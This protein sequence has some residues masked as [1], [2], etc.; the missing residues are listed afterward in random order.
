L[1]ALFVD[2]EREIEELKKILKDPNLKGYRSAIE[3]DLKREN[4]LYEKLKETLSDSP[5]VLRSKNC[6]ANRPARSGGRRGRR[7]IP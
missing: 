4:K 7:N 6:G 5:Y 3:R 2:S 1:F